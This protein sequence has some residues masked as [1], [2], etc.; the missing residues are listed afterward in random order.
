MLNQRR[1]L[2]KQQM[3]LAKKSTKCNFKGKNFVG[4]FILRKTVKDKRS[5][6]WKY[7]LC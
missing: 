2:E 3:A 7:H 6:L 4:L 1:T 5:Q